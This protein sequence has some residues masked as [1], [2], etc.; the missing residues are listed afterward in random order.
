MR[1]YRELSG[2]RSGSMNN[3]AMRWTTFLSFV[4]LML[5]LG[6]RILCCLLWHY[7]PFR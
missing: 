7:E 6:Y 5:S 4:W 3:L 1:F 2:E